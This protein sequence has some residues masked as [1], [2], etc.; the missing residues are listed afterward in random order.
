ML[1]MLKCYHIP[2]VQGYSCTM[3]KRANFFLFQVEKA[4][5]DELKHWE[6]DPKATLALIILQDQFCR[7]VYKV[8]ENKTIIVYV[9]SILFA[10]EQ[11]YPQNSINMILELFINYNYSLGNA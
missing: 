1:Q 2:Y 11:K 9:C 3:E 10:F 4:R 7:S 5:N 8:K 6:E